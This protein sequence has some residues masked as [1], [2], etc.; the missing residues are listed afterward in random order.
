MKVSSLFFCTL[1]LMSLA[2][3]PM[4]S[5]ASPMIATVGE[6]HVTLALSPDPPQTGTEQATVSV[7]SS[8]DA[9]LL[10][11]TV[12]FGSSMPS[13]NMSGASGTA[14]PV[15]GHP[16]QWTFQ[17]PMNEAAQWAIGLHFTGGMSGSTTFNFAVAGPSAAGSSSAIS[18]MS[19]GHEAAWRNAALALIVLLA[20]FALIAW[21]TS[22]SL[23]A[24]GRLPAWVNRST[25]TLAMIA[26]VLVVAAAALQSK[27]APPEMDMSAMSSI[28]GNAPVPVTLAT[29]KQSGA[30][31]SIT[32][33]GVIQANL[34]QEV[35]A[36]VPGLLTNFTAY[37]GT[38]VVAGQTLAILE[39]PELGAQAVAA[40]AAARSDAAAAQAATIEAQHHAP[41]AIAIAQ[42][43]A[44]AKAER[45]RYW[46]TELQRESMLLNNGAV[47][48]QEYQDE[49][50]QAAAAQAE[51]E[52]ARRQ[53]HDAMASLSMAQQQAISAEQRAASSNASAQAAGVMAGYT[54]IIA[55]GDGV[56]VKRLVDPGTYVQAGTPVLR[57]AATGKARIQANVAQ[58]D[59]SA[60]RLG[61]ALQ[62]TL[63]DGRVI[64]A[65][66]TSIQ[67]A[68]D[69]VTHTAVVEAIVGNTNGRFIPGT[70]VHVVINGKSSE[71]TNGLGVPSAAVIGG[72]TDAAVWTNVNGTAH[73]VP[74][75]VVSDDGVTADV[76]GG[77]KPGDQVVVEGAQDLEEGMPIAGRTS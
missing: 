43:D 58:E 52:S 36:R 64:R 50:A 4:A 65:S 21:Q 8:H 46:Q 75:R 39:E 44:A 15:S 14:Q 10:K 31:T 76:V 16:G 17:L 66:V 29:V 34:M 72:G 37:A 47:S 57:I 67:P 63:P 40:F 6:A 3:M 18:A 30:V 61:S 12:L 1:L 7:E 25:I 28:K 35:V 42:E 54:H 27:Y 68:A 77:L 55:P 22:R 9:A 11:T 5:T 60:V 73:R 74:V 53:V 2:L 33:P 13:M 70:F 19:G 32:A 62:A 41:S 24:D 26:L 56:V 49:R 45:A 59:L 23:N 48:S 20:I 71:I 38:H 51:A 69:P